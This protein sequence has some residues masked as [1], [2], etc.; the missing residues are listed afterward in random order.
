MQFQPLLCL[1]YFRPFFKVSGETHFK[2]NNKGVL[3]RATNVLYL[4]LWLATWGQFFR[5]SGYQ[6]PAVMFLSDEDTMAPQIVALI[7][8]SKYRNAIAAEIVSSA[9]WFA[10]ESDDSLVNQ[11]LQTVCYKVVGERRKHSSRKIICNSMVWL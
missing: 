5:I 2:E 1:L 4:W 11:N 7:N 3:A 10:E 9:A 8:Y 6:S